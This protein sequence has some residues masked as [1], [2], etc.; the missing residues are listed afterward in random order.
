MVKMGKHLKREV[1]AVVTDMNQPLGLSVG[2]ALEFREAV[3]LLSGKLP[4]GDPLLEV[5]LLL[6]TQMLLL[7]KLAKTDE[8]ARG[9]LQDAIDSGAGLDKLRAMIHEL[10]GDETLVTLSG[11]DKLCTVKREIPVAAE[12]SGYIVGMQAELIGKAAQLLG[13]GRETKADVIDPAVGLIMHK[14]VGDKV[15]AG[16]AIC[17]LYVND[18][19]NLTD[20]IAT[21]LEAVQIGAKPDHVSPMVYAVIR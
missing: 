12:K 15:E 6:G 20:A 3:Q 21:M 11:M 4:A 10:G 14:R 13:A 1:V 8:E 2:N 18:D 9:M 7:S 5:C 16:E 19:K 17:T